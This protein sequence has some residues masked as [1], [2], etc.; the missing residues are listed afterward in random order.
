MLAR[1]PILAENDGAHH[2]TGYAKSFSK[3]RQCRAVA[4]AAIQRPNARHI[5]VGQ[6]LPLVFESARASFAAT[7][8]TLNQT[9]DSR[10]RHPESLCDFLERWPLASTC[11]LQPNLFHFPVR[12]LRL[13]M[14]LTSPHAFW[15]SM[16]PRLGPA[17]RPPLANHIRAVVGHRSAHE[18]SRIYAT[19]IVATVQHASTCGLLAPTRDEGDAVRQDNVLGLD[20]ELPVAV[21]IAVCRPQPALPD[22]WAMRGHRSVPID[23]LP[24]S[25]ERLFVH[26]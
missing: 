1:D 11:V 7:V 12:K 10:G 4:S 25:C 6:L 13:G 14:A 18:V 26:G 20:A 21:L 15:L 9:S 22:L 3:F 8:A 23:L 16:R 2:G 17:W 19:R 24:E 5:S